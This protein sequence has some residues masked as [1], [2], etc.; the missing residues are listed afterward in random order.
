MVSSTRM[1][2]YD[3]LESMCKEVVIAYFNSVC[4]A[5]HYCKSVCRMLHFY[6]NVTP[7]FENGC[8]HWSWWTY[9][10]FLGNKW[11]EKE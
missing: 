8:N 2:V 3:N 10:Q 6:A 7:V 4:H 11:E 1:T 5:L 9:P